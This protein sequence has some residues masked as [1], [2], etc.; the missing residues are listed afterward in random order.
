MKIELDYF[1]IEGSLG[2][3]QNLF[4]DR[5]MYFGGCAAVTA[6]DLSIYLARTKGITELYPYDAQNLTRED[7]LAFSKVMK[8]YLG[9]RWMGIDTLGLY[10]SG[11]RSYWQDVGANSL[12]L[13]EADGTLSWIEAGELIQEQIDAGIIVP[14]LLLRHK[15]RALKDYHWHWFNVAGYEQRQGE[16]FVKAVSY[17][18]FRWMDFQDLWDTGHKR[19]G[20][21][22]RVFA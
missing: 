16:F 19:K 1:S 2:W 9:P 5:M 20:G 10:S 12:T 21:F 17:G 7:Y 14:F 6:C 13:E 3:N 18:S 4:S 15:N 22:I 11:L 8:G